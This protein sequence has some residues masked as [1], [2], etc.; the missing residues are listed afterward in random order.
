MALPDGSNC[1]RISGATGRAYEVRRDDVDY[2]LRVRVTATN[3]SGSAT[4]ASNATVTV[5]AR[6][7]QNV[8]SPAVSGSAVEGATLQASP[9]TWTGE[10]PMTFDY[11]WLRCS[12]SGD[13]CGGIGSASS[14]TYQVRSNDVGRTLRVQ[15]V[16]R[17]GGGSRV[18]TSGRTGVVQP[19]GPSGVIT[20]PNGDRSIPVTSVPSNQRLVVAQIVFSPST[21]RS[22]VD[23][24]TIRI[25]VLDTRGYVVRDALVFIRATPLV[26]S[27]PDRQLTAVDG[28]VT[29]QLLPNATFPT[30]RSGNHVQSRPI[31]TGIPSWRASPATGSSRCRWPGDARRA[32]SATC[33][34][35]GREKDPV[36]SCLP[37]QARRDRIPL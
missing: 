10:Q 35:V 31:A 8:T 12:T 23:P 33:A 32:A 25:R 4:A 9:G 14:S 5:V 37:E 21:V 13:G 29:Y 6:R 18:A 15:V 16:A 7:P 34:R 28:W 11:Q 20:L 19:A 27:T 3:S 30:P 36:S 1:V 22:R 26:T 17:N 24:I 2:R